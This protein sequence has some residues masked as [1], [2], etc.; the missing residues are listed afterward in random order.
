M[1]FG[2]PV[3]VRLNHGNPRYSPH[4]MWDERISALR[5]FADAISRRDVEATLAVCHPEVEFPSLMA[6]LQASPYR[7]YAG[8]RRYFRDVDADWE[9][10][11]IE[12]EQVVPAPDGRMVMVMST[13]MRG[14]GSGLPF[15]EHLANVWEFKDEKLWRAT[16]HRDPA[17]ALRAIGVAQR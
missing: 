7:G 13:H 5:A 16:L 6:Q 15:V 17:E 11:W 14:R 4:A 12:V 9:E 3:P 10:W 2:Y 1:L 8:I